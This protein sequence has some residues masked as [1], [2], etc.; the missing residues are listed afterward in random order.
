MT[1]PP[2]RVVRRSTDRLR[3][4]WDQE[5]PSYGLWSLL[6]DP[7]VGELLAATDF[8]YVCVDLQHGF[9]TLSELPTLL[10]AMRV[11]DRAPIVRVPWNDPASVMRAIDSGAAGVV[12]PMVNSAEDARLAASA[13]R[14]PPNGN[15]SWGPMW[16]DTRSDGA[17]PP[18]EQDQAV[19]CIVMVE[20]R[21]GAEAIDEIVAVPG[22]DAV[23]IGP[24]DLALGCGHGRRSYRD[25]AEVDA[26]VQSI[27][28]ACGRAGVV[29]GLHCSDVEMARHWAGRGVR[30][31]TA[32]TDTTLLRAAV[33]SLWQDHGAAER[34]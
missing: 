13:C 6:A 5:R 15:R 30:M 8:D 33:S 2:D 18:E 14:F 26:L 23:Y 34:A 22:V 17:L 29:A 25:S 7:A 32:A 11:A 28:D 24:N 4:L 1:T 27:V 10:Q 19:L 16:G 12:V 31:L 3:G 21:E 20:T 9:A